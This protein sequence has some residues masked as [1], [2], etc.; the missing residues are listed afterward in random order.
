MRKFQVQRY[1]LFEQVI[2]SAIDF[3]VIWVLRHAFQKIRTKL[4]KPFIF[5]EQHLL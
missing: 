5:A 4:K 2:I 1:D 3:G